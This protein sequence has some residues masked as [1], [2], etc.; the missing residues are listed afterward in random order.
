MTRDKEGERLGRRVTAA[1]SKHRVEIKVGESQSKGL[2]SAI[3]TT[4]LEPPQRSSFNRKVRARPKG[5]SG[6]TQEG[7]P[8]TVQH[9][10]MEME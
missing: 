7:K 6:Q 3:R 8:R 2:D 4:P 9:S 5:V 1:G 10:S